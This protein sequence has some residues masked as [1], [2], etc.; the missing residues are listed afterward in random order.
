MPSGT[1]TSDLPTKGLYNYLKGAES[2][3]RSQ[4]FLS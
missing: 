1:F 4:Q 3:L 2:F